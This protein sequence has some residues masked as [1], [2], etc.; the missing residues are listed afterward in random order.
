MDRV[1]DGKDPYFF[2]P[3]NIESYDE[4]IF[5]GIDQ[6]LQRNYQLNQAAIHEMQ[7]AMLFLPNNRLLDVT[8]KEG[9]EISINRRYRGGSSFNSHFDY[10]SS[11]NQEEMNEIGISPSKFDELKERMK[12]TGCM[13]FRKEGK[14]SSLGFSRE[15]DGVFY[16]RFA[17]VDD[18]SNFQDSCLIMRLNDRVNL[19]YKGEGRGPDCLVNK[20]PEGYDERSFFQK[21][22]DIL[23]NKDPEI[24]FK[25][26]K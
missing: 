24:K 4:P 25:R 22:R 19:E 16:Y 13:S 3:N 9:S 12:G 8:F 20:N 10:K 21:W 23:T 18:P 7:T 1:F 17:S 15:K 26:V 11:E 14:S 6:K 5:E 2:D